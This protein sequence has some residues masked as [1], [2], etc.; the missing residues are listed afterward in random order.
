METINNYNELI[1]CI[2][3]NN[4]TVEQAIELI[5]LSYKLWITKPY[6]N[7]NE[8]LIDFEKH[9]STYKNSKDKPIFMNDD[10]SISH[11]YNS[12]DTPYPKRFI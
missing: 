5:S 9:H 1:H 4:L 12:D 11:I 8:L 6:T 10:F 2:K 3:S 7:I